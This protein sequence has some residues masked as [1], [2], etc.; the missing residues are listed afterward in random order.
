MLRS[1]DRLAIALLAIAISAAAFLAL[2]AL[3][4]QGQE[5]EQLRKL[6]CGLKQYE[7]FSV[8]NQSSDKARW[9]CVYGDNYNA[10]GFRD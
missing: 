2:T 9:E 3:H 5:I 8:G 10:V 7:D 6:A 1:Y 4:R